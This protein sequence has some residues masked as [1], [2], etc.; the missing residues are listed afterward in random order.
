MLNKSDKKKWSKPAVFFLPNH[1]VS[2]GATMGDGEAITFGNSGGCGN[3]AMIDP[4]KT[5]TYTLDFCYGAVT[6]CSQTMFAFKAIGITSSI[7]SIG[8]CS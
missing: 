4:G 3:A 1:S 6:G 2:S 5:T 7:P 8:I